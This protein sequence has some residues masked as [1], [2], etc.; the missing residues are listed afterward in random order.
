MKPTVGSL[1][2]GVGGI[3]IG[4]EWAGFNTVWQVEIDEW[5]R[6]VLAAIVPDAE[7]FVDVRDCGKINLRRVDCVTG[8]IPCQPF[9]TSGSRRGVADDRYLWPEM[10]RV[11]CALLPAFVLVENVA[12][13]AHEFDGVLEQICADLETA[14]Y[15]VLPPLMVPLASFG[16]WHR[17]DRVWVLAYSD[18]GFR[19]AE[20]EQQ[21]EERS[22]EFPRCTE[23][24]ANNHSQ[25]RNG[26]E[27]HAGRRQ[28]GGGEAESIWRT[29][30]DSEPGVG[31]MVHGFSTKLDRR[32]VEALGE[33][34]S[35]IAAFWIAERI[36]ESMKL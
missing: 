23:V 28:K 1:Y 8:G 4:F 11:V 21:Q 10:L 2:A 34:V 35:P 26:A 27:V 29:W 36:K 9:S 14:H 5:K 30:W 22:Q 12:G 24:H 31:R 33:A 6:S 25:G 17:R 16:A 32:R 20:Q 18:Q 3:D 15:E 19:S 13:L 7:R